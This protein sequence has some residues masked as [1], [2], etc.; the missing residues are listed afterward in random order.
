MDIQALCRHGRYNKLN[1]HRERK[2]LIVN[3]RSVY[4]LQRK[5]SI[6]YS[7]ST[8]SASQPATTDGDVVDGQ[9]STFIKTFYFLFFP[10]QN[11]LPPSP[12][13]WVCAMEREIIA[14]AH[15]SSASLL[16]AAWLHRHA[17][18]TALTLRRVSL[19]IS[20]RVAAMN[21]NLKWTVHVL[22]TS[23]YT[24]AS[25]DYYSLKQ[26]AHADRNIHHV[27]GWRWQRV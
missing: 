12:P 9:S 10:D 19:Y 27:G 26:K 21:V 3:L 22:C 13:G 6:T 4:R 17:Q 16:P 20:S 11:S 8:A 1:W 23:I 25:R 24:R 5:A 18:Y 14:S 2:K 15:Q 7:P